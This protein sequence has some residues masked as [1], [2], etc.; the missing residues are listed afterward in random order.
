[1]K[2]KE[3]RNSYLTFFE[4]KAHQIVD[5]SKVV[6]ES[7]PTLLFTNAGMNQF[8]DTLLGKEKR[9][10]TRAV[11]SQ[12]C[13]RAGGKHND[14]ET[15][16]K[17]G[18]HLTF[19][20][21][22][23]NWSFGDY[24]KKEAITYAWEYLTE[25]LKLNKNS[26]Y[27]SVYKD[28]D[29]SY[30]IW[31][32]TIGLD[33][34]RIFR[35]GDIEK[36]DDENFWSMG[37]I[38]PCGPCTE[39]Y[40]DQEQIDK[41]SSN[42]CQVGCE[43]DKYI[44]LWNLVFMEF[45]RDSDGN[46]NPLPMKSVDT[47]L[48]L[49][50]LTAVLQKKESPFFTDLFDP[51]ITKIEKISNIKINK[52]NI[53]PFRVICDHI[54][55]LTF[56]ITDGAMPSNEG[57]GYV[58]RRILRR[59]SRYGK[60]LNIH[61]PF[62]YKIV[63]TVVNI[64]G[65]VYNEITLQKE[66]VKEVIKSEEERFNLT[67]DNGIVLFNKKA[68]SLLK[69]N[70]KIFPGK[71]AFILYD[72]YGFPLDL[73]TIMAEEKGMTVDLKEYETEMKKQQNLARSSSA[74]KI[75]ELEEK[76]WIVLNDKKENE[77]VGYNEYI[78]KTKIIKYRVKSDRI[79]LI[80]F[81]TP[82]YPE[83]GGQ[84]SD[85]GIIKINEVEIEVFHS[86]KNSDYIINKGKIIKGTLH[87]TNDSIAEAK[88]NLIDR[89]ET[90]RNHTATHLLHKTL[91]EELGEHIKQAGSYVGPDKLRFDFTHYSS[92]SE[93]KIKII[94][95]KINKIIQKQENVSWFWSDLKSALESGVT[96]L[97]DE[98][99]GDKVRVVKVNDYSAELCGGSHV[100]NTAE[101]NLFKI[102]TETA[103]ASGVRR[104]EAL[105]G[106][107]ALN[108]YRK[109][110]EI[111]DSIEKLVQTDTNYLLNKINKLITEN[112]SYKLKIKKLEEKLIS[113]EVSDTKNK[114][115][116]INE[117]P[118]YSD[119]LENVD[120]KNMRM[121]SDKIMDKIKTGVVIL[122]SSVEDKNFYIVKSSKNL[123]ENFSAK[124]IINKINCAVNGR[125]GGKDIF[126]SGGCESKDKLLNVFKE[127]KNIIKE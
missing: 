62:L 68:E 43:C 19:F 6:P 51:I 91:K 54:R 86:E 109:K 64:L 10:Y 36:G 17:D 79:D 20:E 8:K 87:I 42:K 40:Y 98:K 38:G 106:K 21:M 127:I 107:E 74:F 81:K 84:V 93:D 75:D 58:L 118:V 71:E 117:V 26:L 9:D 83:S 111:L 28:D 108:Y 125:G 5:S 48:G 105:T 101:I 29:E 65:D 89:N 23:G 4:K 88:I 22:L 37:D 96:A 1:M 100:E 41:C 32:E 47:G 112:D 55:T 66:F 92:I 45:N 94:E 59:A 3:I 124:S 76:E 39:I 31:N 69:E 103:V 52:E 115:F 16:G 25:V 27:V 49:E 7:D 122:G 24:Y 67:L 110:D 13:I 2:S 123:P 85:T 50:R 63:D 44:E 77:F 15:V 53:T 73:T 34:A 80:L 104:I 30:K 61:N 46:F 90:E 35:F 72:T 82:F 116:I 119:Y 102:I 14:L 95:E 70:K 114:Q 60:L 99:Y 126:A 120:M 113:G 33:K 57:R 11:S 56:A 121:L 12:K 18:R 78:V 97:F